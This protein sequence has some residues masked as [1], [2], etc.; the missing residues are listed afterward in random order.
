MTTANQSGSM[1]KNYDDTHILPFD[2]VDWHNRIGK[3]IHYNKKTDL[4]MSSPAIR[5]KETAKCLFNNE[6]EIFSNGNLK[7]FDCEGLGD[8]KF[9][10]IDEKTFNEKTGLTNVDMA[11]QVDLLLDNF[12][13]VER[14]CDC[15]KIIC[16]SH[17]MVIRYIY[18]YF[19]NNKQISPYSVINSQGFSFANLDMLYVDTETNKTEVYRFKEPICH[20]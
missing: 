8:L 19:N 5:C 16:F 17:G 12:K 2:T 15:D 10:E 18:H 7:E 20:K 11:L 13:E 3:H 9:W 4:I 1:V 14:V 6:N